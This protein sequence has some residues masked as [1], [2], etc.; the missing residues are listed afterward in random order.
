MNVIEFQI[1]CLH[2][3]IVKQSDRPHSATDID[4]P[5]G[6]SDQEDN[7]IAARANE[8][9]KDEYNVDLDVRALEADIQGKSRVLRSSVWER[10][11]RLQ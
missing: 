2:I 6:G 8:S 4:K 5:H 11:E 7:P 1:Q 10:R 3:F 9:I